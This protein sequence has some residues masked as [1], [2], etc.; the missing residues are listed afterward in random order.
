VGRVG[1]GFLGDYFDKRRVIAAAF[2][3]QFVGTL[4]F[5]YI[6]TGLHLAGFLAFWGIGFGASIPVRFA[7][8]AD[9]FGRRHFGS[10]MGIMATVTSVFGVIGPVF[11]G[12]MFDV[13]GNYRDP[14]LIL[15]LA[16]VVGIPLMLSLTPP[17]QARRR[18][19]PPR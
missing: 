11:V 15:S 4:I 3:C 10:I 9:Y 1:G 12:W 16:I 8:L 19:A 7:L 14:Y 2:A 6:G 17:V 18:A 5:A 13:R